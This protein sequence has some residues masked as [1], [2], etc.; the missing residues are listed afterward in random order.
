MP[1]LRSNLWP[2]RRLLES[3]VHTPDVDKFMPSH[4]PQD[5]ENRRRL[6]S[7]LIGVLSIAIVAGAGVFG[8]IALEDSFDSGSR[9][10]FAILIGA[11]V[12]F[13]IRREYRR[14][15]DSRS[16]FDGNNRGTRR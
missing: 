12:V 9:K 13:R 14:W 4:Q 3:S 8:F 11:F 1:N 6:I 5:L 16:D 2:V 7:R 15:V 10:L